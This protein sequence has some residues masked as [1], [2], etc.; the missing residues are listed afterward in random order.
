MFKSIA[1]WK[2]P[3]KVSFVKKQNKTT[4]TKS[5][6]ME[7]LGMVSLDNASDSWSAG[8]ILRLKILRPLI[9]P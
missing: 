8:I 9:H 7:A 4:R 6:E 5:P 1:V 2:L 3:E